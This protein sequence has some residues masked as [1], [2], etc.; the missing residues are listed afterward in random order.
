[1]NNLSKILLILLVALLWIKH[2]KAQES[3]S[4]TK[5]KDIEHYQTLDASYIVGAQLFNDN[6]IYNP[7]YSVSTSFGVFIDDKVVVGLGTG[8]RSFETENFVP[9]YAEVIGFKK[10][11]SSTPLI[12][13]QLGYSI[14]WD[15]RATKIEG[16]NF[17]GGLIIGAGM[18]R[19][20]KINKKVSIL[21]Q[22]TYQHQFAK[23]EFDIYNSTDYSEVLNYD[24]IAISLGL[25]RH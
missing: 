10:D 17:K 13:M 4:V 16:Y 19:K 24:M 15:D 2:S 1:M 9:V 21:F 12:K 6:F 7:G 18:G 14:G 22:W 20:I 5:K 3:D 8:F 25:I 23:M 11:K